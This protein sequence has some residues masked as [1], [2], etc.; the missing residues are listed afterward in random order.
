MRLNRHL[1]RFRWPL[2]GQASSFELLIAPLRD[3]RSRYWA[4]ELLEKRIRQASLPTSVTVGVVLQLASALARLHRSGIVH[5]DVWAQNIVIDEQDK[6]VSRAA[7]AL[8]KPS[9]D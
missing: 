9:S 8:P 4:A 6:V 5:R 3:L 2:K 1:S 7:L